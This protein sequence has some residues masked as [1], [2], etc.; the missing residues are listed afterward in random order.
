MQEACV[1][2]ATPKFTPYFSLPEKVCIICQYPKLL[3]SFHKSKKHKDGRE[4]I[5]KQ[6]RFERR[7]IRTKLMPLES[8]RIL[9]LDRSTKNNFIKYMTNN[10][11]YFEYVAQLPCTLENIIATYDEIISI[12]GGLK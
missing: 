2:A 1:V 4:N 9:Q 10:P 3:T 8:N 6:C 12:K 7:Q 11:H 5:C